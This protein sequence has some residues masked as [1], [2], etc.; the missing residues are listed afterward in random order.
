MKNKTSIVPAFQSIINIERF[1]VKRGA[2][3]IS[4][5]YDTEQRPESIFFQIDIGGKVIPF[6]LPANIDAC[7]RILKKEKAAGSLRKIS[8]K[9]LYIQAE[10]TAWKLIAEWVEIQ[11]ALIDMDQAEFLQVFLPYVHTDDGTTFYET[12]KKTNFTNLLPAPV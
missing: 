3:N 11:M 5:H 10:R 2:L 4:K 6:K 1:L 7:H 12:L 9:N 8:L